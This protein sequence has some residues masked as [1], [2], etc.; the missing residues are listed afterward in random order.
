[1]NGSVKMVSVCSQLASTYGM[2]VLHPKPT[3][4][5]TR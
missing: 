5:P 1:M 4:G 2:L 3:V